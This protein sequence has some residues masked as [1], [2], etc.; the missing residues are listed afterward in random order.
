MAHIPLICRTIP[1]LSKQET[2]AILFIAQEWRRKEATRMESPQRFP[3]ALDT[4]HLTKHLGTSHSDTMK[5]VRVLRRQGLLH[6][7]PR[8]SAGPTGNGW[9]GS[10][11]GALAPS[12]SALTLVDRLIMEK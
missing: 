11:H 8:K 10:L 9:D 6:L 3:V 1:G 12:P 2:R 4:S 5:V 7:Y